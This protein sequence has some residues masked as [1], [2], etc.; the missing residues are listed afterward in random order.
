M[1]EATVGWYAFFYSFALIPLCLF[2]VLPF[3]I[4]VF[5]FPFCVVLAQRSVLDTLPDFR[6]ARL[7]R[8]VDGERER[9]IQYL[10]HIQHGFTY[11]IPRQF[12]V[13]VFR[14][15]I[16]P[17]LVL[18]WENNH[19]FY[20]AYVCLCR[21]PGLYQSRGC[22]N[23][24]PPQ[25]PPNFHQPDSYPTP[26]FSPTCTPHHRSRT[27][28][29]RCSLHSFWKLLSFVSSPC[30]DARRGWMHGTW[31]TGSRCRFPLCLRDIGVD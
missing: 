29:P 15:G 2:P 30:V 19:S 23:Q 22:H 28:H 21:Q 12:P 9:E 13:S 6:V 7:V 18:S 25:V 11:P 3:P 26:L 10:D 8:D 5:P 1:D 24:V 20:Q 27:T 14:T 16:F 31:N 17:V 4:F